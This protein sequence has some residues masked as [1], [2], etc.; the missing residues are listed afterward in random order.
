MT[1][2]H[3]KGKEFVY[4]HHLSVPVRPLEVL[5]DRSIGP[6]RLDGNLIVQGDNLHALKALLPYYAN[7]VDCIFIDPPYNT[8]NESWAYN[9]NVRSPM[10]QEWLNANPI[11]IEDKLRHD[12]WCAMMWVR[13][14][15]LS[16]LLSDQ[17]SIWITLDD[18]ELHRAK[19]MLDEIF[20]TENALGTLVWEKSDS[21]RMDAKTFSSSNDFILA[22]A[23]NAKQAIFNR[24]DIECEE[25]PDHY[26]LRDE[27]GRAYYLKPLRAMG[28]QGDSRKARPK[29]YYPLTAPDE[30]KVFPK[31][32]DGSDGAWRWGKEKTEKE[33]ERIEWRNG[34]NGWK[35]YFRIYAD[36]SGGR[37]PETIWYHLD[38]GSSRTAKAQIKAVFGRPAF[39][40]PKPLGIPAR[41]LEIATEK[42]SIILDSFAGSGT[43][44]HAVL[45]A[46]SRDGGN[47]QFILVEMEDYADSLTA[48]RVRR[49][50]NG[51]DFTGTQKIELLREPLT[52][53]KLQKANRLTEQVETIENLH[54]H[55]YDHIKKVVKDRELIVI[56]EKQV[57][58]R[59][60]GL[61]GEFTYCTLGSAI[62]LDKI[63]TGETLP[64]WKSLG[65]IL[66]HMATSKVFDPA[67]ADE[68]KGYLGKATAPYG[69]VHVWL[70]YR[71]ELDWL[72]SPEAALTMSGARAIAKTAKGDRHVVFAPARHVSRKILDEHSLSVEFAPLPFALYRVERD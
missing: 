4:N 31:R 16:E 26:N 40:T 9:D 69:T 6:A 39:D 72:K 25:I 45:D 10:I 42:D 57:K 29:L 34:R 66:F 2:L 1:E 3:F 41:V 48:E 35:P 14:R 13:L 43:T 20:G 60:D 47:R 36:T 33:A 68:R 18:N 63:L 21:P 65:S 37:P 44:A 12:K 8:G 15:L 67:H 27:K 52:W 56:G 24:T 32:Q 7:K 17:G 50:I 11:G 59:I 54:G 38:V 46:N 55:E 49:I 19:L 23:K 61:G 53:T 5:S 71:P 64:D 58:D 62:E 22:Y 51:Y 30:S 28:G 70:V